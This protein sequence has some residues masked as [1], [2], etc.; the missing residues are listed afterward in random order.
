MID[1]DLIDELE[2]EMRLA[3]RQALMS[4]AHSGILHAQRER[5]FRR[6]AHGSDTED[7]ETVAQAV[8]NYRRVAHGLESLQ[9]AGDALLKENEL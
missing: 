3:V 6:V 8:L 5:L 1:S 7:S 9:Q 2:P 4:L